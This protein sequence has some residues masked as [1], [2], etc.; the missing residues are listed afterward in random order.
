MKYPGN[1]GQDLSWYIITQFRESG[2]PDLDQII[3]DGRDAP[4]EV[5]PDELKDRQRVATARVA[6]RPAVYARVGHLQWGM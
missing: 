6:V 2:S 1:T 5:S 4:P 3:E